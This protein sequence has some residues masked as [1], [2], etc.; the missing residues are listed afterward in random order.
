V[1]KRSN[2]T[3]VNKKVPKKAKIIRKARTHSYEVSIDSWCF[4]DEGIPTWENLYW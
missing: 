3:L 2:V 1:V 4:G